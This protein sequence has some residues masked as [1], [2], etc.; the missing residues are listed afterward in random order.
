M[1]IHKKPPFLIVD[2]CRLSVLCGIDKMV[3]NLFVG[4]HKVYFLSKTMDNVISKLEA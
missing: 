3:K 4:T 2:Y 1:D